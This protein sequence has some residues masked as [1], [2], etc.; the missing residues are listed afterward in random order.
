MYFADS[1]R[2]TLVKGSASCSLL[3]RAFCSCDA[4][5][6]TGAE[7]DGELR[8][9]IQEYLVSDRRYSLLAR[10]AIPEG[11]SSVIRS[12][13]LVDQRLSGAYKPSA[14]H[15]RRHINPPPFHHAWHR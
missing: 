11:R 6:L 13:S 3:A 10:N 15:G 5:W 7:V 8:W 14:T 4:G 1:S 2:S 12:G 9:L